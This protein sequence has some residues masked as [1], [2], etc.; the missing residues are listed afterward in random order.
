MKGE[1]GRSDMRCFREP[2][3]RSEDRSTSVVLLALVS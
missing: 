2:L 3:E 1:A